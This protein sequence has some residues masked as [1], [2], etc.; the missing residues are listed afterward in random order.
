MKLKKTSIAVIAAI[1]V[2]GFA[3]MSFDVLDDNGKAGRTGSPGETTCTGCHTGAVINDGNGS[4][5]ISSPDLGTTWEYMPG[6]TYTIEVTVSRVGSPLFGF[7]LE[8]LTGSTPAQ[9]AG[10]LVVT[11]SA[12]THILNATVSTVVRKNM[13]HQLNGGLGTDTKTF[14]FHWIAPA[15]NIGN[16]TFY[17][18]GN[19]TNMNGAKT[20]DHIYS[21]TQVVTPAFGAGTGDLSEADPIFNV[22]P[23]PASEN[24]F[25]NYNIEAGERVDFTLT[26]LDGKSVGPVYTFTGTGTRATSMLALPT[27]LAAGIYF[28]VMQSGSTN[29]IRKVV[30][31]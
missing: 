16:V 5:V 4:V 6:D 9:N 12:E 14:S 31:E 2:T 27:D 30:I 11:N 18:T 29:S 15:T 1:A 8:C 25:V 19:A 26:T 10:T 3:T 23:N 17:C 7:D 13:T 20:G 28:I 21:T 24:I 22:F